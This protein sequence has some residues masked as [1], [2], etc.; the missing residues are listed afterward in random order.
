MHEHTIGSPLAELGS[1]DSHT[2][3]WVLDSSA[4]SRRWIALEAVA[5]D[6][7]RAGL[8]AIGTS[9]LER[10]GSGHQGRQAT[11]L[12]WLPTG[13]AMPAGRVP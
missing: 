2:P 7:L 5:S 12:F 6:V 9:R 3:Q 4:R 1:G 11:A 13:R 8:A 10:P